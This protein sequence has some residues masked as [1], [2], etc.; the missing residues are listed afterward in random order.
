MPSA[1][2]LTHL[3]LHLDAL[4]VDH[5]DSGS[6]S[7]FTDALITVIDGTIPD[8]TDVLTW[9]EGK[10]PDRPDR[11]RTLAQ[12]VIDRLKLKDTL[13]ILDIHFEL[14]IEAGFS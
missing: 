3:R 13:H 6:L 11:E 5:P 1:R 7:D 2:E 14:E 10:L 4:R 8:A 12:P 9:L